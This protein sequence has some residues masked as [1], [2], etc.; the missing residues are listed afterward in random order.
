MNILQYCL[1]SFF[2]FISFCACLR[3]PRT[4]SSMTAFFFSTITLDG[5]QKIANARTHS[6]PRGTHLEIQSAL[7]VP[8]LSL[9]D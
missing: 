2:C 8:E 6:K 1:L 5:H 9:P 3:R 4:M 7:K